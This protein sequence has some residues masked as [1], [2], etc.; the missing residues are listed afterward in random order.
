LV[1]GPYDVTTHNDVCT[2]GFPKAYHLKA[3]H[4]ARL[5]LCP[6][7]DI[8][9]DVEKFRAYFNPFLEREAALSILAIEYIPDG[10]DPDEVPVSSRLRYEVPPRKLRATLRRICS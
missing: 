8:W 10:R 6:D 5:I 4:S 9:Q 7:G 1:E 2:F 3:L